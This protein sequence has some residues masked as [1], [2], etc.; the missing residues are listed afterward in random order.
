MV[1][2]PSSFTGSDRWFYNHYRDAMAL[3]HKYGIPTFF[4]TKTFDVN[5]HEVMKE[6][7]TIQTP[8]DHP[9]I[10]CSIYEMKK[11]EF[12][13]D[14]TVKKVLGV[15][16]AHIA[17]IEFQKRGVPH[18]HIL[19]WIEY[20]KSNCESIDRVICAEIPDKRVDEDLY[21]L[22]MDKMI[23]GQCNYT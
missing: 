1:I 16:I 4:I 3:V 17:V 7:K 13:H 11:K 9:D 8:F 22:F 15:H 14:L 10:I 23:H 20:F 18:C 21:Q 19:I 6:L 12:I 5:C 2:L